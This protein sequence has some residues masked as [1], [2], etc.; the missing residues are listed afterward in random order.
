MNITKSCMSC[1]GVVFNIISKAGSYELVC[2]DCGVMAGEVGLDKYVTVMGNCSKCSNSKFKVRINKGE[3]EESWTPECLECRAEP[4][5]K[6]VNN[7]LEEIDEK[8]RENL[9]LKDRLAEMAERIK[10]LEDRLPK[11]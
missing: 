8:S 11:V 6:Y 7:E 10:E 2:A 4:V 1:G 5:Y 3:E 9:I